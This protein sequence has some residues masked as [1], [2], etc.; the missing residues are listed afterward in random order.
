MVEK[1]LFPLR[2]F[3]KFIV[4]L[5]KHSVSSIKTKFFFS[6][7]SKRWHISS[8]LFDLEEEVTQGETLNEALFNA[9]EVL[10]LVM[11]HH[12]EQEI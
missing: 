8:S 11:E 10:T 5:K 7:S 3:A 2:D 12:L 6:D 9:A 1:V 4:I